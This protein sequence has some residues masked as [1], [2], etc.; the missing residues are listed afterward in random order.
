MMVDDDRHPP[1]ETEQIAAEEP[2]D[3][4]TQLQQSIDELTLSMFNALRLLPNDHDKKTQEPNID[5][6]QKKQIFDMAQTVITTSKNINLLI[7]DLPGLNSSENDQIKELLAAEKDADI[8][9]K[10]LSAAEMEAERWCDLARKSLRTIAA[11]KL[12][13]R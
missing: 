9:I 12:R 3:K 1:S 2:L 4:V 5:D 8:M 6:E 11:D 13:Y 7:N 10:K